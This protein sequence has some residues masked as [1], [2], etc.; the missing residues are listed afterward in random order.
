ML[1]EF[2]KLNNLVALQQGDGF[3]VLKISR[4]A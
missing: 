1:K 2:E 3:G 4:A